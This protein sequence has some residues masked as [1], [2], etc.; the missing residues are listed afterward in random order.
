MVAEIGKGKGVGKKPQKAGGRDYCICPKCGQIHQHPRGEPC[1]SFACV[2]CGS[3][4]QPY[5]K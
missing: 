1:T 3:R 4:L 5:V 2:R